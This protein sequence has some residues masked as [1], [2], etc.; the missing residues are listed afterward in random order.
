M[1]ITNKAKLSPLFVTVSLLIYTPVAYSTERFP[2]SLDLPISDAVDALNNQC[3]TFYAD[4]QSDH[5]FEISDHH[6]SAEFSHTWPDGSKTLF[7]SHSEMDSNDQGQILSFHAPASMFSN[8]LI[9]QQRELKLVEKHYIDEQ[10]PSG[11]AWLPSPIDAH[12]GVLVIASE[13]NGELLFKHSDA[14]GKI[15][16]TQT[17]VPN[18]VAN[19]TDVWAFEKDQQLWLIVHDMN[20]GRGAAYQAN[21]DELFTSD[22]QLDLTALHFNNHYQSPDETGCNKSLG[23]NAQVVRD[24]NNDW[25]VVHTYSDG[26]FCGINSG[27]IKIKAYSINFD[28]ELFNINQDPVPS[29]VKTLPYQSSF[30]GS[31]ADGAAGFRIS[32]Q[33]KLTLILGEQFAS[34]SGFNWRSA[35]VECR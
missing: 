4:T 27:D 31:G 2:V 16:T 7:I 8:D 24:S 28:S 9:D 19:I 13:E 10:H 17:F 18:D 6:Q 22:H 30:N 33:G 34:L 20:H 29:V 26:L 14:S 3:T 23:Q 1:L 21:I 25:Y 32:S 11:M 12:H 5:S 35:L 15:T